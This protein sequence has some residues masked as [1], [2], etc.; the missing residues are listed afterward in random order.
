[1]TVGPTDTINTEV[2]SADLKDGAQVIVGEIH[3]DDAS[4]QTTNPFA[5]Q[6]F[7]RGGRGRGR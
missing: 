7:R 5:P 4:N 3:E 6:M 2:A 1:V